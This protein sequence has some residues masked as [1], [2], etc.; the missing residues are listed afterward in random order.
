MRSRASARSPP[1]PEPTGVTPTPIN[2]RPAT[3]STPLGENAHPDLHPHAQQPSANDATPINQPTVSQT[4]VR[5]VTESPDPATRWI[6][7]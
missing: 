5:A 4:T 6:Q 3:A 7:V 2:P 1:S